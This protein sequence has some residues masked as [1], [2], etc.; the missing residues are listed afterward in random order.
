[1]SFWLLQSLNGLAFGSVLFLLSVGLSL[2]FGLM[3]IPNLAHG[4]LFM[5]GAYVGYATL[6]AGGSFWLAA[7]AGAAGAA[8]FGALMEFYLLRRLAG[9]ENAQV[10]ATTGVTFVIADV[11]IVI[12]GGDPHSIDAPAML[13]GATNVA[14][15]FMPSYRLALIVFAVVLAAMLWFAIE[16]TRIGAML[17]AGVDDWQMRVVWVF[18]SIV[19]L[20]ACSCWVRHWRASAAF[21]R[22]PCCRPTRGWTWRCFRSRSSWSSWAAWAALQEPSSVAC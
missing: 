19:F 2:I 8:L 9:Q 17:R 5:M 4:G 10:L 13:R 14:G 21:W 1:M 3:R 6:A 16:K 11:V 7:L 20:R 15:V 12:W 18:R 22:V